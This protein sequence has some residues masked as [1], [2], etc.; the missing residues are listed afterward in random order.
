MRKPRVRALTYAEDG[1]A[2]GVRGEK[3]TDVRADEPGAAMP[4][5]LAGLGRVIAA[6]KV[7]PAPPKRRK[8]KRGG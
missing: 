1:R 8:R 6:G 7:A 3:F 2:Y 5:F 4:A